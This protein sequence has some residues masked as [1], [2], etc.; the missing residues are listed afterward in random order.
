M[1]QTHQESSKN[2]IVKEV[3]AREAHK[4]CETWKDLWAWQ[5]NLRIFMVKREKDD[6]L[7]IYINL[8]IITK[9]YLNTLWFGELHMI[10]EQS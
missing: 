5:Y 3:K 8:C 10:L 4:A 6:A 2:I 7:T 1:N 9:L